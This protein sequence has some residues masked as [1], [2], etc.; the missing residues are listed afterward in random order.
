M[1]SHRKHKQGMWLKQTKSL[2]PLQNHMSYLGPCEYGSEFAGFFAKVTPTAQSHRRFISPPP[3]SAGSNKPHRPGS[4][5]RSSEHV[6]PKCNAAAKHEK[7]T[8]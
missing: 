1:K 8:G 6:P 4:T 7:R 5:S 3:N 2:T